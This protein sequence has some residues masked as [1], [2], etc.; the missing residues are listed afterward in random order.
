ML[1]TANRVFLACTLACILVAAILPMG[2]MAY[3]D[4]EAQYSVPVATE[5]VET[6]TLALLEKD[7]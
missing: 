5:A 7:D 4:N 6:F 2:S 3:A 1:K